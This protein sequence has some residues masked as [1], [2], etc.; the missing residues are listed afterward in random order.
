MNLGQA[1]K[2]LNDGKMIARKGWNGKGLFVFKQ[3][4]SE[5]DAEIVPKMQS[6]PQAVKDEF[7]RR[8]GSIRYRNQLAMVYPDN[9]VFGWTPSPS[10]ALENDWGIYEAPAS[11]KANVLTEEQRRACTL[12][13]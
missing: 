8:G 6:L 2:A 9:T 5:I 11:E 7:A 3:V 13:R 10:D 12:G 1:V 4:T